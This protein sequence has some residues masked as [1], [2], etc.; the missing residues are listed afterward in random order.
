VGFETSAAFTGALVVWSQFLGDVGFDLDDANVWVPL[1]EVIGPCVCPIRTRYVNLGENQD[2]LAVRESGKIG[3][4]RRRVVKER[5][6]GVQKDQKD[7]R[8]L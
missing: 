6:T 4:Q 8:N 5:T 1:L 2:D 7:L 3:C